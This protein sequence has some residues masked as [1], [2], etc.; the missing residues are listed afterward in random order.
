MLLVD[1][2]DQCWGKFSVGLGGHI[3][4]PIRYSAPRFERRWIY[5]V[6]RDRFEPQQIL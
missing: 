6:G 2:F 4:D 3:A 1:Y 5:P